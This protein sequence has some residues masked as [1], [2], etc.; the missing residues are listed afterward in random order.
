MDNRQKLQKILGEKYDVQE[1]IYRGGM[2]EIYL[3][4]HRQ[5]A[6]KVAIK[7]MIQKLTDDPEL[8]KRFHREA[9]LYANLRH[10]N[11]IHIYDFGTE[12]AFDYM[13]FPFIDGETLQQKLKR[14]K[15]FNPKESLSILISVAKAL[16]YASANNVIHRDV[17]PSNIM[18]ER[19]GN[20]LITDFG[21][22]KD[23]TDLDITLPGTVLGSPKYMSPEQIQGKA[24]DS[25]GD[26]YA[27]GIIGY[28]MLGGRYPFDANNSSAL[29]YSHV[30]DTPNLPEDAVAQLHPEFPRILKKMVAKEPAERYD[31]FND[32]IDDLTLLQV[33]ETEIRRKPGTSASRKSKGGSSA[34]KYIAAAL[35]AVILLAVE[36][37]V[38]QYYMTPRGTTE[39]ARKPDKP[40]VTAVNPPKETPAE[41]ASVES[42]K[43][44][45]VE[46]ESTAAA[47]AAAV[48]PQV[49]EPPLTVSAIREMLYGLGA[50]DAANG[51][52]IRINQPDFRIGEM[53]AYTIESDT[54]CHAVLFDFTTAGEMIQLFPNGFNTDSYIRAHTV[55]KIPIE[56]SFEITGPV[57]TEHIVGFTGGKAV[58]MLTMADMSEGPF[59]TVTNTDRAMLRKISSSIKKL[60][61][62][63]LFRKAV[64]FGIFNR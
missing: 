41:P 40:P 31:N 39:L 35:A 53:I 50:M 51:L 5:L 57:G 47:T 14:E 33:E 11:I 52:K 48:A 42:V 10:P 46:E 34:K 20:V 44:Q 29:F 7:I 18:M 43:V 28:E 64:D 3:G 8:K 25:R 32:L 19:N 1:M 45:P 61:N 26:Q 17:K 21:I 15:R 30:H 49:S 58:G 60:D 54:D 23:L 16:A 6:A 55:Y 9:Q 59:P 38:I 63:V 4:L 37:L 13:V 12:D 2:G 22:S 27:L 62:V 36:F 56:G 24:V